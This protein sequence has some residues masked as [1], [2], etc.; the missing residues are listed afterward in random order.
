MAGAQGLGIDEEMWDCHINHYSGYWWEDIVWMGLDQY[1]TIL[2]WDA[3]NWHYD[4]TPETEDMYWDELTV[5][6]Q[7]AATQVCFFRD[8]WNTVPIPE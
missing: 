8:L 4:E 2:G 5:K 7:M 1:F 3:G 6:Q